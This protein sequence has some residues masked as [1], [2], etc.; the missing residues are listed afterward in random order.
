MASIPA[1]LDERWAIFP[2]VCLDICAHGS[3]ELALSLLE[4]TT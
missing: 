3:I 2:F 4:S 1:L